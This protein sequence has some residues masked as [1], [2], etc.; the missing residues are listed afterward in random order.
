MTWTCPACTLVNPKEAMA[1]EAC[2]GPGPGASSFAT[3]GA[4]VCKGC[5]QAIRRG[6]GMLQ[7]LG[8]SYHPECFRCGACQRVFE[9]NTRFQVHEAEP[10]HAACFQE[11]FHPR[12]DVCSELLPMNTSQHIVYRE[13]PF[14]RLK[15]CGLH[16]QRARCCSCKRIEPT[17]SHRRFESLRDGRK[18]CSE[19]AD[20]VILDTSEVQPVVAHVWSFLASLGMHLP[21]LPVLLVD[22]ETLNAHTHDHHANL[23]RD[24]KAPAIY[25][26][27]LS[28]VRYI[29]HIAHR[30]AT[31][32]MQLGDRRVNA[33]LILHGLP[34]DMTAHILAH[35]ATHAYFK[36]HPGFPS[37]LSPQ[38]EEGVCQL[39][40]YLYLEY[41]N[42]TS[43]PGNFRATLRGCYVYHLLHDPSPAYGDGL[44]AALAA[45][46][47]HNSLQAVLDLVRNNTL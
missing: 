18:L 41:M 8:R 21:A 10:Y 7:A 5:N 39:L 27:C 43:A 20:T 40:A 19:C 14:W 24:A 15:Y 2:E 16:D 23:P 22:F 38:V 34:Y 4:V 17:A 13:M 26:V 33:I 1:C 3:S 25:G 47:H 37:H 12:C 32:R 45:Y 36:L 6:A 35:E 28:E 31:E 44:R 11:L 42:V 30:G 29:Q 9:A 46:N